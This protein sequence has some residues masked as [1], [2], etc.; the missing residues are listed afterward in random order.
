MHDDGNRVI[1]Y[2]DAD[3]EKLNISDEVWRYESSNALNANA[4]LFSRTLPSNGKAV[5]KELMA[6]FGNKPFL[7]HHA[8]GFEQFV[9]VNAYRRKEEQFFKT[10][11]RVPRHLVPNGSNV[12]SSHVLYR[13]KINDDSSLQLK[14]R[15]APHGNEDPFK[16]EVKSVV[17]VHRLEFALCFLL[18]HCENGELS[19]QMQ[20]LHSFRLVLL[21]VMFP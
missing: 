20:N 4:S 21:V 5:V 13:V 18:R 10:A 19:K 8:Q 14:A 1:V 6:A 17:F 2:D 12:I 9:L 7:L 15:I 16:D 3:I 11:K